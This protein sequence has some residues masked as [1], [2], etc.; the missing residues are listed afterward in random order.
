MSKG[1][2]GFIGHIFK[3]EMIYFAQKPLN[4]LMTH[5][6]ISVV[7]YRIVRKSLELNFWTT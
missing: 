7:V 6:I 2:Y 1:F 4:Y 3:F 5:I